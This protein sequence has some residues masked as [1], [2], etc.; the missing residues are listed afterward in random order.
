MLNNFSLSLGIPG[1]SQAAAKAN[2]DLAKTL[3]QQKEQLQQ[4]QELQQQ[5][6]MQQQ[7]QQQRMIPQDHR[8]EEEEAKNAAAHIMQQALS[9]TRGT[10]PLT[11]SSL[12]ASG[13]V[14][15]NT[16]TALFVSQVQ[17]GLPPAVPVSSAVLSSLILRSV[18][19]STVFPFLVGCLFS[20]FLPFLLVSAHD[21][22]V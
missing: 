8:P 22:A 20:C 11:A 12:Q 13:S 16:K 19:L 14:S 18:L 5:L 3:E 10:M 7:L 4:L 9:N 2:E 15:P 17:P 1:T 21:F 6:Q